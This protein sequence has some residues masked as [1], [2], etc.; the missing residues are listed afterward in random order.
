MLKIIGIYVFPASDLYFH[1][2]FDLPAA[3][4]PMLRKMNL[5]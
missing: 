5:I 3:S 4:R 2:Q 1:M